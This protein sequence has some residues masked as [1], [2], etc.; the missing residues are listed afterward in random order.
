MVD[1][2]NKCQI[3]LGHSIAYYPQGNVLADSSN[4]KLVNII[5]N[6]LQDNNN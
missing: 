3:T 6:L 4:K 5:K 1:F 2:C